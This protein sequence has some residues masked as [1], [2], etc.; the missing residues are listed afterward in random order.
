MG[1][2]SRKHGLVL[3]SSSTPKERAL[4]MAGQCSTSEEFAVMEAARILRSSIIEL[5]KGPSELPASLTIDNFQ[6]GQAEPP[7]ILIKFFETLLS[8]KQEANSHNDAEETS[9]RA[10]SL[11]QD[12]LFCVSKGKI[13]PSK[14]LCMGLG[15]KSLTGSRKVIE[16]L[17]RLGHSICY[18]TAETIET[19]LASNV[20]E[21]DKLIPDML[22]QKPDLSTGLAWDNYDEMAHTLSGKDTLHD[23]VGICYQNKITNPVNLEEHVCHEKEY[24]SE[25]PTKK[26]R[27]YEAPEQIIVPYNRRPSLSKFNYDNYTVDLPTSILEKAKQFNL[28]WM[29][30]CHETQVTPMWR[31]WNSLVCNDDLPQQVIGYMENIESLPQD[32][33]L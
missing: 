1:K 18:H 27:K 25:K 30:S 7:R 24:P 13:K 10:S 5:M 8:S 28:I 4:R 29:I 33:M 20:S 9:R 14:H 22:L 3:F 2:L 17:N 11:S 32:W 6:K 21:K 15:M 31:G 26:R 23:T 19:E 12:A 16:I